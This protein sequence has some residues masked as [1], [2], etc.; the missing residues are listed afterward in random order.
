M[1]LNVPSVHVSKVMDPRLEINQV[2]EYTVLK[3]GIM[4]SWQQYFATNLSNNT[5]G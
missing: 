1:S 3:G 5:V 4:N 2:K